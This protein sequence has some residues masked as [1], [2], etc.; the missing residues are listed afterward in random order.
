MPTLHDLQHAFGAALLSSDPAAAEFVIADGIAPEARLNIYRNTYAG[1]L[2][3]AL[4][5]SYPAVRK[6]VG[7]DFFEGTA[8]AFVDAHPPRSAYLNEYGEAFAGFLA[9]FP[10]AASV[11]YLADVARLEWAVNV[12][13]YA[14]NAPVLDA[15]KLATLG[16]HTDLSFVP[17]PSVSLVKTAYPANAIWRAVI[18]ENDAALGVV[19][20]A[21]G[22]DFLVVSRG[23][24]GVLVATLSEDEWQFARA[25]F[26]GV[27]ISRALADAK[28]DVSPSLA[29][30][31]AAGR[32]T[33]VQ[34]RT[35]I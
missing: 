8:R 30:H 13:L 15:A 4:R 3:A 16:E 12:A 10:P 20:L 22:P 1:N 33:D 34:E 6:L 5:I 23:A 28:T 27:P 19:D 35:P 29:A 14:E 31:L 26:A 32:F 21:Q 25:L 7:D 24:E 17:H 9:Q 18:E 2:V 11:P